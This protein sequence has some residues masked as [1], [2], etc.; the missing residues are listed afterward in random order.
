MKIKNCRIVLESREQ[1]ADIDNKI[2]NDGDRLF[3]DS[4]PYDFNI[5][6]DNKI[7][8]VR[9][10]QTTPLFRKTERDTIIAILDYEDFEGACDEDGREFSEE[11]IIKLITIPSTTVQVLYEGKLLYCDNSK[12]ENLGLL[13]VK[14]LK[15]NIR[16]DDL[17]LK[18]V[19]VSPSDNIKIEN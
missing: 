10:C 12:S 1:I 6:S 13:S 19:D 5:I 7:I 14:S 18:S 4:D 15:F 9:F 8:T 17:S 11:E 16:E 2:A 3:V